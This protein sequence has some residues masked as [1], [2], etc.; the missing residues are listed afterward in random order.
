RHEHGPERR[1][2][3]HRSLVGRRR[4]RDRPRLAQAGV[5]R[6]HLTRPRRIRAM[7]R[8]DRRGLMLFALVAIPSLAAA[9]LIIWL[10]QDQ[11]GVPNPSPVYLTAVVVTALAVGSRGAAIV[12]VPSFLLYAFFFIEPRVNLTISQPSEWLNAV[13]LLFVGIVVGELAGLQRRRTEQARERELEAVALFQLSRALA[14]RTSTPAVLP[15][16]SNIL[17][18]ETSAN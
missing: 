14:T 9:T 5:R 4:G 8:L 7:V 13:L 6:E 11:L 15:E 2:P 12:A 3:S 16:I 18:G 17:V 1:D 10:L